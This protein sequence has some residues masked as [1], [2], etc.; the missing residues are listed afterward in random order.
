MPD[1]VR[2]APPRSTVEWLPSRRIKSANKPTIKGILVGAART[3][4]NTGL[5]RRCCAQSDGRTD[6]V[7]LA[8]GRR[9]TSCPVRRRGPSTRVLRAGRWERRHLGAQLRIIDHDGMRITGFLTTTTPTGQLADLELRHRRHAR[10]ADRSPHRQGHRPAQRA[11]SRAGPELDLGRDRCPRRRSLRLDRAP[12]SA[13]AHRQLQTKRRPATPA[14][15]TQDPERR[16][17]Q[18]GQR[19]SLP[20]TTPDPGT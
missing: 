2:S 3:K 15:T 6:R 5:A 17:P 20:I 4:A 18:E 7:G 19:S 14:P 11:L 12:G 1:R 16:P 8:S 10:V 13:R 9:D